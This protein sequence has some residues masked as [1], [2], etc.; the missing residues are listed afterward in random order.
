MDKQHIIEEIKRNAQENG[1]EPLGR[2][3]FLT[4]TGIRESDWI[5]RYW[6]KWS[7]AVREAG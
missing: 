4:E 2:H 5:G 7:D 1:G 3:R 6:T